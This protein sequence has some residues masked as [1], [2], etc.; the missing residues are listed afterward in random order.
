MSHTF[1]T[2]MDNL[3]IAI[4]VNGD[5][6][7]SADVRVTEFE[8]PRAERREVRHAR[9]VVDAQQLLRGTV[10]EARPVT[11]AQLRPTEWPLVVALAVRSHFQARAVAAIEDL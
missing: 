10:A 6:S 7:G 5:W 2:R 4:T 11:G 3:E 8:G 9:A 1:E